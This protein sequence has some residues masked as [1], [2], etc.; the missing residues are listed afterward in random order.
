M[1]VSI[2]IVSYNVKE[3]LERCISSITRSSEKV[4][5]IVVDNNSNDGTLEMLKNLYP[6]VRIIANEKNVGFSAANNQG[7]ALASADVIF[8]LNPDTELVDDSL[9]KLLLFL[10]Q[11]KEICVV[12]PKLLNSD[13]SLQVSVW[14]YPSVTYLFL[15]LFY[16]H[17]TFNTLNYSTKKMAECFEPDA[18]SGAALLFKRDLLQ[19]V[20]GLDPLFFW[21]ED[22]DFCYRAH[23]TG[24]KIFYY[25]FAEI[26]H[27][28]GKSSLK[29]QH[30][31]ISN[32]LISK[33]KF[34]RK[35][36]GTLTYV[37]ALA[38]ILLHIISR[39]LLLITPSLFNSSAR[40]KR[41]AYYFSLK[42]YFNFIAGDRNV[43]TN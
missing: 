43:I 42:K 34:E 33:I 2:I 17:R 6:F 20:D 7:I 11:Q 13:L 31:A 19:K 21:M 24:C 9:S 14:K 8:L 4:E 37:I 28:S 15:E 26:I 1:T 32:Q 16:L 18:L 35:H 25:P 41:N 38:V 5:I 22:I 10:N 12:G 27:Y 23:Q 39:Y 3:F 30:I 36:G 29:N 40:V